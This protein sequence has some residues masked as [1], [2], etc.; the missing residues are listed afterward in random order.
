MVPNLGGLYG[1]LTKVS[2]L[3]SGLSGTA[4]LTSGTLPAIADPTQF[5]G[6][7]ASAVNPSGTVHYMGFSQGSGYVQIAGATTGGPGTGGGWIEPNQWYFNEFISSVTQPYPEEV[8]VA[9]DPWAD[10]PNSATPP[11]T[12]P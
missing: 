2:G 9:Y 7:P 8:W 12:F 4:T 1:C 11:P 10:Y 6:M 5:G 3:L